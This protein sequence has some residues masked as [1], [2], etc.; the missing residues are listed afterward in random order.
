MVKSVGC[1][2]SSLVRW[3]VCAA[4]LISASLAPVSAGV[5][6]WTPFGPGGGDL[7]SLALDPSNSDVIY[8]AAGQAGIYKSTDAGATWAWLGNGLAGWRFQVVAVDPA[9]GT[10]YTASGEA[11]ST[12]EVVFRSTNGG[13]RWTKVLEISQESLGI[14]DLAAA[15][16]V[17]YVQTYTRVFR[18]LNRG[19]SWAQVFAQGLLHD[20]ELDP[21]TPQTAWLASQSGLLKTTD[22]G[23]SWHLVPTPAD[24]RS[25]AVAPSEP[26]RVYL[27]TGRDFYRSTD[28]G[29]TWTQGGTPDR[30]GE[31]AGDPGDP[32]TVYSYGPA[33]L[34]SRDGGQTWRR[35]ERGLPLLGGQI[36][37]VFSLA[38][39][40]DRPG[41]LYAG[42]HRAGLYKAEEGRAWRSPGQAG[43]AGR[44]FEWIKAHPRVS[45]TLYALEA[46][47]LWRSLDGGATWKPFARNVF[48]F[49]ALHDLAFDPRRPNR[50]AAATN[51]G[52]FL[53]DDGGATWSPLDGPRIGARNVVIVDD[54]TLLAGTHS[55][56]YRSTD[57]GRNWVEV[58]DASIPPP[59]DDHYGGRNILWL[60][61]DPANPRIVYA[62]AVDY[63]V[64]GGGLPEFHLVRSTDG[65]ATWRPLRYF[66][67]VEIAPGQPRSLYAADGSHAWRSRDAGATWQR[68]GALPNAIDL[69][70]DPD[71]PGTLYAGTA[72]NGVHRSTNGGANW[73]PVNTGL[74]RFGRRR[75][76]DV[77]V[78]PGVPGLVYAVPQEGGLFQAR[79]TDGQGQPLLS[80]SWLFSSGAVLSV[81]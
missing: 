18:S 28:A 74:A 61:N 43:L 62:R 25:V 11:D 60:R 47:Q 35:L 39:R 33:L 36:P 2:L 52:I 42:V 72:A 59:D 70:V 73:A 13:A 19:G 68:L 5:N 26:S 27:A 45:S 78:N 75:I 49:G 71:A 16:G 31:L 3:A 50:M 81:L 54:R 56:L 65:G 6:R 44:R 24:V 46:L 8:A 12:A 23:A 48:S 67:A 77:E 1:R 64:G 57:A 80:G 20:I 17:V 63:I 4:V 22:A 38:I 15:D 55:G 30:I 53:S 14:L 51:Q 76:V 40:P 9:D 79:F 10:L 29:A 41:S 69:E 21:D 58:F 66:S 34:V 37:H 32:L 7:R